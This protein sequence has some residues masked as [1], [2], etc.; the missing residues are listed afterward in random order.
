MRQYR[1]RIVTVVGGVLLGIML[2]AAP[3]SAGLAAGGRAGFSADP[4]QFIIGGQAVLGSVMPRINLVPSLDFGFGNDITVTTFNIDFQFNLP[5]LPKVSPNLYVGA[6]PSIV[7]VNPDKGNSDTDV[8]LS[9]LAGM[10]IPMTGVSY[11]NLEARFGLENVPDL[12]VL[13]GIMFGL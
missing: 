8:G 1:N 5:S 13:L 11:Y 12:K 9:L 10:R 6:G 3:A 4:D 2:F 7:R